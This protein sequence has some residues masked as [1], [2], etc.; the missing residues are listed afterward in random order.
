MTKPI[1]AVAVL[2]LYEE[3]RFLLDDPIREFL[4][5]FAQTKVFVREAPNGANGGG[6]LEV[7]D[8]ERELTIRQLLTHTSG[9][10]SGVAAGLWSTAHDHHQTLPGGPRLAAGGL[11]GGR[12]RYRARRAAVS[13]RRVA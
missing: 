3:G 2:L 5:E 8:L 9:V 1:T 4:P 12:E 11:S 13:A 7:A 10:A 6:G